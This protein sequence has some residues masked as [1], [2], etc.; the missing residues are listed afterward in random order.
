MNYVKAKEL[1]TFKTGKLD[2][3]AA[4]EGGLYPFFTCAQTTY[5]IN[6]FAFDAEC[7][8]LAGNNA[9]A[10]FPLK[11]YNGKFNAYQRTYI[12]ETKQKNKLNIRYFYFFLMPYLKA[13][14]QQATGATTKF[15]TMKILN[16]IQVALPEIEVQDKI[17]AIL[18]A[19]DDLIE[20]NN[21]RIATLEQL[22][23]QIYKEW[24]VR[25][26]FPGWENTQLHHGI[27]DGWEVK[28]VKDAFN[29]VGGGT[30][31]KDTGAY[32]VEGTINWFT[33][34]NLTNSNRILINESSLKC[35]ETGYKESSARMFPAYSVMM[36]SRATIGAVAINTTEA[37][38]NQGFITCIP[39]EKFSYPFLFY[40]I[41]QNRE[42]F[43]LMA[44]GA[45]FLEIT[46]GTFNKIDILVPPE[47]IM[48]RFTDMAC[49]LFKQI[50]ILQEQIDILTKTRNLLLPR[51]ISGKLTL[52]QASSSL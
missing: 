36:T 25:M 45:T 23:Q 19:Y 26:R 28:K 2:S 43:M 16:N 40:W 44:S 22:A 17:A 38:T 50:E 37:C 4:E 6:S 34:T 14:E 29:I 39:N 8:L 52:N 35:N 11:Y 5:Q 9:G 31:S 12:I 46:K 41:K 3:N 1:V 7:V 24:F 42:F 51:L 21:Q 32:W 18:S 48:N 13:F 30:P 47:S 15:L 33:P 20:T 10:I 49:P 27:P